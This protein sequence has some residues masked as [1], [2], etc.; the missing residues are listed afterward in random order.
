VR[1]KIKDSGA[2]TETLALDGLSVGE[3]EQV[4]HICRYAAEIDAPTIASR[5]CV[6]RLR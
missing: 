3:V 5:G 4:L 6:S 2:V 1:S